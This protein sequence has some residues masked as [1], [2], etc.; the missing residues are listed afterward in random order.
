MATFGVS[1]SARLLNV[2]G[3]VWCNRHTTDGRLP[4]E[5]EACHKCFA[6]TSFCPQIDHVRDTFTDQ[7]RIRSAL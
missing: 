4:V 7:L 6:V 2:E 3:L 1:R 5:A